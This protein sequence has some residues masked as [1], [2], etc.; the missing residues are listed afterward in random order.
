M[1]KHN[2]AGD[3]ILS[4]DD[5]A[6]FAAA[7]HHAPL[8]MALLALD[9]HW[10]KVNPALCRLL[11]YSATELLSKT[12]PSVTLP[13][14]REPDANWLQQLLPNNETIHSREKR[15]IHKD[16]HIVWV[17]LSLAPVRGT[18]GEPCYFIAQMENISIRIQLRQQLQAHARN[19]EA[20]VEQRTQDL[21][22]ANQELTAMNEEILAMNESLESLNQSL[23][24]EIVTRRQKET[25]LLLRDKQY[26]ATANLLMHPDES[27]D[28]LLKTI[29]HDVIQLL[30]APG[31]TIG[32]KK[33]NSRDFMILHMIGYD[34]SAYIKARS[35]DQGMLGEVFRSGELFF[36]ED[37]H[38]YPQRINDKH[39]DRTTAVIMVPLKLG[40]RV[41]GVLSVNWLDTPHH[42]SVEDLEISRQFGVLASV[43]LERAHTSRQITYRNQLLEKLAET[44]AAL[45]DE[46]DLEKVLRTILHQAADFMDIPHGF[47]QLLDPDGKSAIIQCGL[48]N[49]ASQTGQA[50]P[51]DQGGIIAEI[52]AT[53][54]L[55]IVDDYVNWPK[56]LKNSTY[57]GITS[58]MQ[59]PLVIDGKTIGSIGL[60]SFGEPFAID[61]VRRTVFEQFATVATI[62]VKNAMTHRKT[63]FLA[64]HDSLTGLPNRTYLNHRLAAEMDKAQAGEAYGAVFFIDLDDLKAVNDSFGH[65]CGD[66][67]IKAAAQQ[68]LGGV[69]PGAFV[70][71]V[72]GDEFTVI[73]PTTIDRNQIEMVAERLVSA[74][75]R[76]YQV[77]GR[78]IHMSASVG[79]TLYPADSVVAEELLKNADSA[80]YAAKAAGRNCWRLYNP[81]MLKDAYEK[82]SLTNSLRHALERNEL[83]LQFQPQ[84]SLNDQKVNGFEAL[85]RWNSPEHGVVPPTRFIPLAEQSGLILSIGQWVLSEACRFARELSLAGRSDVHVAVNVSPRQLAADDF[86]EIVRRCLNDSG[87]EPGQLEI[88]ITENVLMD[89][90]EDSTNKLYE[91]NALAVSLAL[92]DFGT[93]FSSLT[94]LRSLPVGRLKIDKSFIDKITQDRLQENFVRSIIDMAHA[95]GLKVT[96]EGVET[97]LQLTTLSRFGCDCV[98]GY[99]YSRPV[100]PTEALRY[101]PPA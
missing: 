81:G 101:S 17:L 47:I 70:A 16:G 49:Y 72:G 97:E 33:A 36:V 91:L 87:I 13:E 76:E 58:A 1:D 71:R 48:G 45:V 14:D 7:F 86:V 56:R 37:Y 26:R 50:I 73:L 6:L 46:L 84:I 68:I 65:S 67:V 12:L 52:F 18:D 79:I 21:F 85:L 4:D 77:S 78:N 94:Y 9:G 41:E 53:G 51:I 90:L 60:S 80:M 74:L 3:S 64:F 59:A 11:G 55:T 99:W 20:I 35:I 98:Q 19:L 28:E 54:K 96:D 25:E 40:G 22:S 23:A 27:I 15:Y 31:G 10:F 66:E 2:L 30:G 62:A 44:T 29:L 63:N 93:G 83:Y 88:E 43:V 38:S 75:Q 100:S 32:V 82:L 24:A 5:A 61:P 57:S 42:V 39:F 34:A 69:G 95:L 92:D 8:G 89:S